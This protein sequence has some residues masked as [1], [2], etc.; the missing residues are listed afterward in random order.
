MTKK[1]WKYI[2][3]TDKICETIIQKSQNNSIRLCIQEQHNEIKSN[4]LTVT[5]SQK[6][7]KKYYIHGDIWTAKLLIQYSQY[8]CVL[9]FT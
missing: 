7:V 4:I 3:L 2:P 6:I 5:A 1:K 9:P 8:F